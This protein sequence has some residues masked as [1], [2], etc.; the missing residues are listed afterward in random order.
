MSPKDTSKK[1]IGVK[2]D[3]S[4]PDTILQTQTTRLSLSQSISTSNIYSGGV[5]IPRRTDS[6]LKDP[7]LPD[8]D[9]VF[10]TKKEPRIE[11]VGDL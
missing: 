4:E 5:L 7:H 9:F 6:L 3:P 1:W 8:T 11:A 10:L 2:T